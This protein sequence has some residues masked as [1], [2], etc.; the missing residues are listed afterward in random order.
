MS[1]I[2]F[3][4]IV[5]LYNVEKWI[6]KCLYSIK[7][8]NYK[9][10]QCVV[11]DDISTDNTLKKIEKIISGDSR[12]LLVKNSQKKLALKNIY[13]GIN[14]SNPNE[15]DVIVTVDG[16]DWLANANVLTTLNR[17]YQKHD[18]W[19]TYGSYIE[20]PTG[21]VGKFSKQIPSDVI[22]NRL[23]RNHEWCSSHLRTFKYHLWNKI[24][25]E[26]LLDSH[27]NFYEMAWDL[28]FM[29]PMLEM[30]GKKSHYINDILYV[31]NVSNPLNDHK[32]DNHL[33]RSLEVEIR[34]KDRYQAIMDQQDDTKNLLN[35]RRFDIASKVIFAKH[36]IKNT[37][38]TFP[39]ETYLENLKVWNN[40]IEKKP[41]KNS[42][43]EFIS[44]FKE[45]INSIKEDGFLPGNEI[46]LLHGSPINGAHRV[47]ALIAL[48]KK[49]HTRVGDISEGQYLC[50]Y[51]YFK[52]KSDF[53]SGGLNQLYMDEMALEFC[54]NKNNLYC[55]CL[56]PSH[57]KSIDQLVETIKQFNG[58][59][60][61]KKL[62]L[63]DYGKINFMHNLYLGESWL[64][65]KNNG[66]PGAKEK[67]QMCFQGGDDVTVIMIEENDAS[68]LVAL[69]DK[70]R[71]I[72][73]VGKHSIHINDTQEETWRIATS[74]FNQN[75][76]NLLNNRNPFA[77]T[78]K[79]D[80][81]LSKYK[82][83]VPMKEADDFCID[84]SAVLS[85][86]GLRD[87]R[88]LDYIHFNGQRVG[89]QDIDCHNSE[90]HHYTKSK[91]EILFNPK[92]HFYYHGYKFASIE[93]VRDMKIK[94]NE[95]KDQKD[96]KLI[97]VIEGLK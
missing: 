64:G 68:R 69:K 61:R 93:T 33:Q 71:N 96:V 81:L 66:L 26:D 31:Y 95:E 2:H 19:M 7:L 15:E 41:P 77:P 39:R 78:A 29:F 65:N 92:N 6:D 21:M 1:D 4:I 85:V 54:R 94:R 17:E 47:A 53:V 62:S 88:D 8:Q 75:S 45:T 50:D 97:K 28:S 27:G 23:F 56:F 86:Y 40:F 58:I 13:D 43:G 9:N 5:P 52:N 63:T 89:H 42:P 11:I 57:N 49:A 84:S 37:K 82:S 38:T 32:K 55:V 46:P 16:D 87:C 59:V 91:D 20:Y 25:E 34:T 74:V 22:R 44:S 18:C 72:C 10:F 60:Y 14:I 12:F 67:A 48:N 36:L 83:F 3:K 70:I 73:N 79:F 51:E 90:L 35:F 76:V 80:V 24:K 30:S